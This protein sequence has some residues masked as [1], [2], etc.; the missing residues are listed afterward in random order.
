MNIF[1]CFLVFVILICNSAWADS[2][3]NFDADKI[4]VEAHKLADA[5]LNTDLEVLVD[6]M[7]PK[8]VR[9]MGGRVKALE[10]TQR[11]MDNMKENGM[12]ILDYKV[13]RPQEIIKTSMNEIVLVPTEM[14][15]S[16]PKSKI[17][18]NG[19][20]IASREQKSAKWLF[21]DASGIKDRKGLEMLFPKYPNTQ[22]ISLYHIH[23]MN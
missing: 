21:I 17:R 9:L 14:L 13:T 11:L 22:S 19:F 2:I 1:R 12:R 6:S 18:S 10:T 8:V 15:L 7:H 5:T 4:M 3:N 16:T 23:T 20:L